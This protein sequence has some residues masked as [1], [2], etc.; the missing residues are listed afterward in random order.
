MVTLAGLSAIGFAFV[1]NILYYSRVW[2]QATNDI[3]I[4]NPGGDHAGARPGHLHLVSGT[5]CSR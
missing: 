1:E 3:T 2:M 4:A 5:R